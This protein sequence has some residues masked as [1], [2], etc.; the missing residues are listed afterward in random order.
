MAMINGNNIKYI[1]SY[2]YLQDTHEKEKFVRLPHFSLYYVVSK[3][4]SPRFLLYSMS[5]FM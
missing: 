3:G 1:K 5:S 4:C 2:K